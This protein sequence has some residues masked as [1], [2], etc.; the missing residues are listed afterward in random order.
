VLKTGDL[1]VFGLVVVLRLEEVEEERPLPAIPTSD[2][3]EEDEE[4]TTTTHVGLDPRQLQGAGPSSSASAAPRRGKQDLSGIGALCLDLLPGTY[5][6]LTKMLN[7]MADLSE[8]QVERVDLEAYRSYLLPVLATLTRLMEVASEMSVSRLEVVDLRD[9]AE[10]A[11]ARVERNLSRR[12]ITVLNGIPQ[13]M[14]VQADPG[15]L[16]TALAGLLLNAGQSSL[17]GALVEILAEEDDGACVIELIDEGMG[18]EEE[19][20]FQAFHLADD[21]LPPMAA[22]FWEARRVVLSLGGRLSVKTQESRGTVVRI[23][24]PGVGRA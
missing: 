23:E 22:R 24:L 21:D 3:L 8:Q 19:L 16:V 4:D 2:Y 9:I 1:I 18:H 6:R 15:R 12:Q 7:T 17:D 11:L 10:Q 5:A 20:L 13:L 14:R